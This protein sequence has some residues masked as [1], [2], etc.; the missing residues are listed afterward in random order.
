MHRV[1]AGRKFAGPEIA[2]IFVALAFAAPLT[3]WWHGLYEQQATPHVRM[4]R[5]PLRSVSITMPTGDGVRIFSAVGYVI[6]ASD[7][8]RLFS[9][10]LLADSAAPVAPIQT[11]GSD[12]NQILLLV[13]AAIGAV[14]MVI[15]AFAVYP[16]LRR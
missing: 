16:A 3:A 9:F 12:P 2:L 15:Y 7:T 13:V 5:A 14:M 8:D 1:P 10:P 6:N 4:E 11:E